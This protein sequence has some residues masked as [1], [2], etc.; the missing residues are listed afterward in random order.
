MIKLL[1]FMREVCCMF[2]LPAYDV[3][4]RYWVCP[5]RAGYREK[6]IN[7]AEVY[8][9]E[10]TEYQGMQDMHWGTEKEAGA[11]AIL[12]RLKPFISDPNI[13]LLRLGSTREDFEPITCKDER[14]SKRT[15]KWGHA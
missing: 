6:F 5:E 13:V 1:N 3:V 12:G 8:P 7:A 11:K 15:S 9:S 4:L 14:P 2:R 10:A